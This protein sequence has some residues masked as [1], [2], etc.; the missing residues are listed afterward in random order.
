MWSDIRSSV[1][2]NA[3]SGVVHDNRNWTYLDNQETTSCAKSYV[4]AIDYDDETDSDESE[5]SYYY[6]DDDSD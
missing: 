5:D 4:P 6:Y 2:F 3:T 1:V